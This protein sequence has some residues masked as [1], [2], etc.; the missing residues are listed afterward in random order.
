MKPHTIGF[1]AVA[2]AAVCWSTGGLFIKLLPYTP[3]TIL[4][5]RSFF[6]ALMF[7]LMF[8]ERVLRF[9]KK[10]GLVV[11][12][13]IG[14]LTSYVVAVKLTTAANAIFLQYTAPAYVLLLEPLLFRLKLKGVDILTII[15]CMSGMLL[16]FGEDM[17]PGSWTGNL[18][19]LFSGLMLAGL[20]LAQ[21]FNAP[22]D[23]E[24]AIF[25]GNIAVFVIS[26]PMLAQTGWP[27]P[28]H[29]AMLVFL[30]FIQ[31]GGGYALFNFGIKR[32]LAIEASLLAM[33]EPILNPVWVWLGY[34]EV[35]ARG[36]IAGGLLIIAML[37][38]RIII[39][40]RHK[41]RLRK[42]SGQV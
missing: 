3:F 27:G 29:W 28:S 15:V 33:I 17:S 4:G 19:A 25:W 21:R 22:E 39:Q 35:P 5:Y 37:M 23:H 7:G 41:Y 6:A 24:A 18:L 31:L 9:N 40:E 30:G 42:L 2:L 13:Y 12:F 26:L 20:M 32:I 11:L 36:A 8:R 16:F 34:G 14:L 1:I 10:I 38:L